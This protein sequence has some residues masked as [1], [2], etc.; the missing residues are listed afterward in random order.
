MFLAFSYLF[1]LAVDM[2]IISDGLK[3][4]IGIVFGAGFSIAGFMLHQKQKQT[5]GQI[6][7]GLGVALL[8]TTF[9]FAGIYF[10]LWLPITV[11]IAMVA[12]TAGACVYS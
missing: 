4:A 5:S 3:I 8:Y 1:K 12:V 2:G 10:N 9:S 7:T 11:F 6:I